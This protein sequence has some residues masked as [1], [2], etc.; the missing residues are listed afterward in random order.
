[1]HAAKQWFIKTPERALNQAYTAALMIRFIEN[2]HSYGNKIFT[3]SVNSRSCNWD[4]H[5]ES[6][7]Q[8]NF[9]K[10]LNTIRLRLTEFRVSYSVLGASNSNRIERLRLISEHVEKLKVIDEVLTKYTSAENTWVFLLSQNEKTRSSKFVNLPRLVTIDVQATEVSP[11][12][13]SPM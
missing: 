6:I 5:V 3:K 11:Q 4:S 13:R 12:Y 9:D 10:L 2:E 1:L 7:S 8:T